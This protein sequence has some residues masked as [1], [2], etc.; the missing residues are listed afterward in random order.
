MRL[1]ATFSLLLGSVVLSA[2][3]A[4]AGSW[5]FEQDIAQ[6]QQPDGGVIVEP[7]TGGNH[8]YQI[9]ANKPSHTRLMLEA[10]NVSLDF[11]ASLRLRVLSSKG[12]KPTIFLYGRNGKSGV[13]RAAD[14]Q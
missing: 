8:A 7:G 1:L 10:N 9:L 3:L 11:L 6:W 12:A 14:L 2:P 13:P 5:D 4:R